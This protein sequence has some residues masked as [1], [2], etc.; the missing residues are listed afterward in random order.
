MTIYSPLSN[1]NKTNQ[2]IQTREEKFLPNTPQTGEALELLTSLTE[3]SVSLIFLDPQYQPARQVLPTNY[4]LYSQSDYQILRILEQVERVLKPSAFCLLWVNKT[5]LGNDRITLWLLKTPTLKIV[6]FLVWHKKNSLGLGVWLRSN[7]E[8]CFLIQKFPTNGKL[9]KNRSFGNV[10]EEPVIPNHQRKHP[11]Q[12][13]KRLI[14]ALIEATTEKGELIVDPCAGSFVVLE[15]CQEL[16][17]EFMG[18]DLTYQKLKE[19][20]NKKYKNN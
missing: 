1:K 8:F 18:C 17:R 5:L 20:K 4:P 9:F 3:N 11:H 15:V 6:D 12:K 13:P 2:F 10:W 19:F 16:E 7:A 14:K